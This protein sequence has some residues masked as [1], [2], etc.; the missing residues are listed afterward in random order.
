MT[1][2]GAI[3]NSIFLLGT[4]ALA[5]CG[6]P[7]MYD[8]F[9]PINGAWH[10]DS[11]VQFVVPVADNEET[12]AV[13]VKLRHNA[14]YPYSN[15]YMFRTISSVNGIEYQDTVNFTLADATGKWL[16]NGIGEVKTMVWP[17]S[18]RGLKF[19]NTGKYTFTLQQGMRD[20]LLEGIMDV[21]LE[22]NQIT[23]EK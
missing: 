22:I 12:Y 11:V 5:A 2:A 7:R 10:Q 4:L 8:S 20:T 1:I 21:G 17:Y 14:D 3:R 6:N 19:T 16:G 15:L 13:S 9:K 23:E 18:R